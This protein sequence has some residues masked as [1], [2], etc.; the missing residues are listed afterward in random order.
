MDEGEKQDPVKVLD[1]LESYVRPRKNKRIS[2]HKLK[3]RKQG[4]G[5]PFDNFVK[6][7]RLILMDCEY[8]DP[9][10]ILIDSIIDGVQAKKLQEKL[11]DRGEELTLADAIKIGQQYELSQKQVRFVRDEDAAVSALLS[12]TNREP[13]FPVGPKHKS[14]P[15][16][17]DPIKKSCYRC[18]KDPQHDW[19]KGKCPALGST[20]SY[21]KKPNHWRAVCSRRIRVQKLAVSSDDD[22]VGSDTEVLNIHTAQPVDAREEDKW[23]VKST[24]QNKYIKF[25]I[26]TGARCNTLTLKDYQKA[27]HKGELR[28][29]TKL[30]RT[31]SNHQIKPIATADLSVKCNDEQITTPFQIV[32]LDQENVL[33]GSTAEAP[34]LIARL[35]SVD[36]ADLTKENQ[37]P[38]GLLIHT[39]GT[40]P[41]TYTIKLKSNAKGVVHAPRRLPVALKQKAIDKLHE[42]EADGFITR[43]EEPT[44]W[45]SSM[46]VSTR[47]D[48]IRI[49]IDPSDLNKVIKREHYP[50]RTI[51]DVV[52][53][54]SNAKVFSKL[55]AK[56]G[57]LQIKL[58]E[59]SSL[60]TTFNTPIGRC[61]WLRL[62]FGLKCAPEIFQRI[63]DQM[64]EGIEGATAVMDDILIAGR[65]V[66]HHDAILRKVIERATSYNL[67]LNL[68]K[69][70]V[71][72][73]EV[74][75]I[76]HLLTSEGLKPDPSKV[77]AVRDMPTP[78]KKEDLRR[79]LGFVTY[80]GKFIPNLSEIGAPL[81]DLLKNKVL[82]DWQPAHEEAF[83]KL[84]DQCCTHPVLM[85]FDVNKQ[86][87]I[88][89][90]ASQHGL[91][92]VLIQAGRPV[93]YSSRSL[94][95][96]E[97]RYAQIEKEMLS[98][99][100][101]CTKFR[102]HILGK[103]VTVYN[104]HKPFELI[105]KKPLLAA[106][107]RLQ[108][109]LLN[110]QQYD[111]NVTYRKGKL[112]SLPDTLSRAHLPSKS[113]S[114]ITNLEQ[115]NSL[116]FLSV[117]KKRY[118]EIQEYTQLE[119][120]QLQAM[121]LAGW[122]DT[123]QEVPASLRPYWDSRGELAVSD[124][125]CEVG[126]VC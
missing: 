112:M 74:P 52:T 30:L 22:D 48:K 65:D 53:E 16:R 102:C 63:K 8:I 101:A 14:M 124:G 108:R 86:V 32:D 23:T 76:G 68:Q 27:Q 56:S 44:E 15:Q 13:T 73:P 85:F 18:G 117:T 5:E 47:G 31:Y 119:L 42:M 11:L 116:D 95:E 123:R 3:L 17:S 20:C 115:V 122:P 126:A 105:C 6:D 36:T 72:Q 46:V 19:N 99:V 10:G 35:S 84:K 89:C 7:L 83:N 57:F 80:L 55:D 100:H 49:C 97:K 77:A 26:D 59:P 79:F 62:P 61:K 40:L 71:R 103:E 21:C 107:V 9:D 66:E 2:R 28:K 120:N 91:G 82:F 106:P 50:M 92:A 51:E 29:S 87:E 25:R 1:K 67:K 81:R 45:V 60:L 69:C 96:V 75:Y 121:V 64:L 78:Q 41:G 38:E 109:M 88:Q 110:L 12:R 98:I 58:D 90:D 113:E 43:M 94:T 104:D 114:E 54:I 37:V 39:T 118:F 125:V 33:S 24:L 70:F 4:Q 111:L 93:A 34:Q